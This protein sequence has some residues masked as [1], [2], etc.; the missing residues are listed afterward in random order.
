MQ[1]QLEVKFHVHLFRL[2]RLWLQIDMICNWRKL[3]DWITK[4]ISK[5]QTQQT[6]DTMQYRYSTIVINNLS[7]VHGYWEWWSRHA[8]TKSWSTLVMRSPSSQKRTKRD[9]C[10]CTC[11]NEPWRQ[12]SSNAKNSEIYNTAWS[13][14]KSPVVL[15]PWFITAPYRVQK[16]S[17]MQLAA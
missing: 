13:S 3:T 14:E 1:A 9:K 17:F 4:V 6:F 11:L 7:A 16:N 12:K 8:E 15:W 2:I 10:P 5:Q